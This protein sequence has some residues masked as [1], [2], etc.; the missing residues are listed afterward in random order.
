MVD[1]PKL[2]LIIAI[3]ILIINNYSVIRRFLAKRI[4]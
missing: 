1:T 3:A 2:L 4:P